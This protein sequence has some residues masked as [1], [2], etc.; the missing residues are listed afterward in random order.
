MWWINLASVDEVC[1]IT[2]V[3]RTKQT[4]TGDGTMNHIYLDGIKIEAHFE[5]GKMH[6][7][8]RWDLLPEL[9]KC[10]WVRMEYHNNGL[11]AATVWKV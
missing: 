4:Q 3:T 9:V 2:Y 5:N 1:I 10:G 8:S 6:W 7:C 11:N